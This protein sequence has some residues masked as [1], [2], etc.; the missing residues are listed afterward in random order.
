MGLWA[1]KTGL[2]EGR[3]HKSPNAGYPEASFAGA[4]KVRLGGPNVYHGTLVE[5]PHIG[6]G[7]HEPSMGTIKEACDLMMLSALVSF[8]IAWGFLILWR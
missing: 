2:T 1:F 8:L 3:R 7:F 4:L 5:K 6:E